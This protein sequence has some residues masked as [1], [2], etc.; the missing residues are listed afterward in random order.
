MPTQCERTKK[1]RQTPEGKRSVAKVNWKQWGLTS[2][3][4]EVYERYINTTHCDKCN[5]IFNDSFD[6][7]MDHDHITGKFRNILCRGC[8]NRYTDNKTSWKRG[9]TPQW[10]TKDGKVKY[11]YVKKINGKY[12]RKYLQNKTEAI[13]YKYI[14]LL[15]LRAG[16]LN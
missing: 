16:L 6:K 13:C 4:D 8:N 1:Y 15:K 14:F 5:K 11:R 3:F 2:D 12:H 10:T 7:C 9:I